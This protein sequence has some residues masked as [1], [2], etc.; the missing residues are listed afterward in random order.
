[1]AWWAWVL[2]GVGAVALA[3]VKVKVGGAWL[4]RQAEKRNQ[5]EEE[6]EE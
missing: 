2:I 1:M 4:K 6:Y 3:I 5:P